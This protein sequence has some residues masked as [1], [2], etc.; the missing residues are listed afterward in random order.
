MIIRRLDIVDCEELVEKLKRC[1]I[2]KNAEEELKKFIE[3][4]AADVY[5]H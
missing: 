5:F 1:C 3:D 2:A 4:N